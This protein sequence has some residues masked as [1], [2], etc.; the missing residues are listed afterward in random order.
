MQ[1]EPHLW[2][3]RLQFNAWLLRLFVFATLSTGRRKTRLKRSTARRR[4][5]LVWALSTAVQFESFSLVMVP[6]AAT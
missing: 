2:L 5:N 6:H 1:A 4:G 3:V